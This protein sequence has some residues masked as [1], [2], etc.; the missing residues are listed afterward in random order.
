[1]MPNQQKHKASGGGGGGNSGNSGGLEE[2]GTALDH[3][4]HSCPELDVMVLNDQH[5]VAVTHVNGAQAGQNTPYHIHRFVKGGGGGGGGGKKQNDPESNNQASQGSEHDKFSLVSRL[6]SR[7]GAPPGPQAMKTHRKS[8]ARFFASVDEVE[9]EL[10]P[11][12][13]SVAT[14]TMTVVTMTMNAGM[15][16]LVLNFACSAR[17]NIDGDQGSSGGSGGGSGSGGGGSMLDHLVLFPTDDE[18]VEVR[19]SSRVC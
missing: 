2:R 1:M 15:S 12:L 7:E 5:C 3:I 18:A 9:A 13:A 11:I 10:A 17:R 16:D 4:Q 6:G 8:L 19:H 14:T